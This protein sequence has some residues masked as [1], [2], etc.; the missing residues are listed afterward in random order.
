MQTKKKEMDES[1]RLQLKS[2]IAANNTTDQTELIRKLKHSPQI[3]EEIDKLLI[4]CNNYNGHAN[5]D[6]LIYA[7]GVRECYFLFTFY[8]DIFNKV[9]KDEINL[10]LL[11]QF[12]DVLE[13]IEKGEIDQHEGSFLVGSLLKDIYVD[14]AL[15]RA[16]KMDEQ[17]QGENPVPQKPATPV[18]EISWKQFKQAQKKTEKGTAKK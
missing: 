6:E 5:R 14:S 3:R 17:Y 16:E 10:N 15:K 9:R 18:L 8:S 2:M 13:R 11:R 12:L 1:Q 4:I 7:E